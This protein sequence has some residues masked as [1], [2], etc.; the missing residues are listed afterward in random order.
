M[1]HPPK[2]DGWLLQSD[3][4]RQDAAQA[5]VEGARMGDW[6]QTYSGR[7]F[8][9]MDPRA[10]EVEIADIAHSLGMQCRY[11][12][13]C[14]NFYSVAEHSVHVARWLLA[15]G[16][17]R[18]TALQGLLH[19]APEAYLVDVPR[20]VKPFLPGYKEAEARVW[21]EIAKRFDI[22]V[23]LHPA[24]HE[25]DNRILGDER[26]QN[27]ARSAAEWADTGPPLDIMI[28][29]WRPAE[30]PGRFIDAFYDL[31]EVV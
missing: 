13:H 27:M 18:V 10:E 22:P 15:N 23:R 4:S 17:D 21:T 7:Q 12:G 6:M 19:D 28:E 14:I 11:A 1:I 29:C 2:R 24:V 16:H 8:W 5:H 20:P 31:T 9:P 26:A 25:A 3:K 30:A